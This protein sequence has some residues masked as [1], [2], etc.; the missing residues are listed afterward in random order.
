VFGRNDPFV[1]V[2]S[3]VAEFRGGMTFPFRVEFEWKGMPMKTE[4]N[5]TVGLCPI[6]SLFGF[7]GMCMIVH[8]DVTP[9]AE[10][11]RVWFRDGVTNTVDQPQLDSCLHCHC[12][13]P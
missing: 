12:R 4:L 1:Y 3:G 10:W 6:L 9:P 8:A 13:H 11:P 5:C 2:P 7:L